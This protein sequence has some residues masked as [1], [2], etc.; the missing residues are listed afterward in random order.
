MI[1]E[2]FSHCLST[3]KKLINRHILCDIV[4][5]FINIF[6]SD[7]FEVLN[8]QTHIRCKGSKLFFIEHL[9]HIVKHQIRTK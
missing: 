7:S 4:K 2:K 1:S 6:A 9:T 8:T 5:C 3:W